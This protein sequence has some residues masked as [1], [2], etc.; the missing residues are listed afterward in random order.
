MAFGMGSSK[1]KNPGETNKAGL[2]RISL[3][4]V[5]SVVLLVLLTLFFVAT[6]IIFQ[7][8]NQY[9]S[10]VDDLRL[11]SQQIPV[12]AS[13]VSPGNLGAFGA[14]EKKVDEFDLLLKGL[15]SSEN[16]LLPVPVIQIQL[17]AV[18]AAWDEVKASAA[19]I[20]GNADVILAIHEDAADFRRASVE[21]QTM[22]GEILALMI[23]VGENPRQV[24]LAS[25]QLTYAE[26]MAEYLDGILRGNVGHVTT[27]DN[28][29]GWVKSFRQNLNSMHTQ[30]SVEN[31]Q[32]ASDEALMGVL[33]EVA[34]V[35]RFHEKN[36]P[37]ITEGISRFFQARV[38]SARIFDDSQVLLV[39]LNQLA[40]AYQTV[41]TVMVGVLLIV[42]IL[43][44]AN[45]R[46]RIRGV[47]MREGKVQERIQSQNMAILKLLN[48]I[49]QLKDGDLTVEASV[50]EAFTGRI[51]DV[52]NMLVKILCG[53]VSA[54]NDASVQ[55]STA[56]QGVVNTMREL[57]HSGEKQAR[58]I[59]SATQPIAGMAESMKG[60]S[61]EAGHLAEVVRNS[62][63]IANRGERT[64]RDAIKE[65]SAIREQIQEISRRLKHLDESSQEVKVIIELIDNIADQANILALNA[66]IQASSSG[67]VGQSF[68]VVTDGVQRLAENS[69]NAT[70]QAKKLIA[71]IQADIKEA[72]ISMEK[73]VTAVGS[74]ESYAE[75]SGQALDEIEKVLNELTGLIGGISGTANWHAER[76]EKIS[77]SMMAIRDVVLQA[78]VVASQATESNHELVVMAENLKQ[79]TSTFRLP[80]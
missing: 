64:V 52:I 29:S 34:A 9:M 62:V 73:T 18:S 5:S 31:K 78:S 50:N 25:L 24:Y 58:D 70:K 54:I 69:I 63:D 6:V 74:G 16:G 3:A 76:A 77:R 2:T 80:G 20:I 22:M 66:T 13:E 53:L 38:M 4:K 7:K 37:A 10:L 32:L 12:L 17:Q 56:A 48:E 79:Q 65:M 33:G 47:T 49:E 60:V 61:E 27:V 40:N 21:L 11:F 44:L 30:D 45:F 72:V 36:I 59:D 41:V 71:V 26:R 39:R 8:V 43:V 67:E 75:N 19:P 46:V 57:A 28:F 35:F 68:T 1:F 23:E 55:I 42:G 51:A 15:R 14:L